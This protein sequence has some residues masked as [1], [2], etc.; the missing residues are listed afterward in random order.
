[1]RERA[2]LDRS[3]DNDQAHAAIG[4]RAVHVHEE[5]LDFSGADKNLEPSEIG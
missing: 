5:E 1:M 4:E 3:Q 2:A